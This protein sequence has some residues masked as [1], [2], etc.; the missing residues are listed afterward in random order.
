MGL[1]AS[2]EPCF[3]FFLNPPFAPATTVYRVTAR[4]F[5]LGFR[6]EVLGF[7]VEGEFLRRVR[8]S[9]IYDR[10]RFGER[11]KVQCAVCLIT[12]THCEKLLLLTNQRTNE[13]AR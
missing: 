5:G 9:W 1:K 7:R 8:S 3:C 2:V 4:R 13:Q 12:P 6:V 10:A 11:V